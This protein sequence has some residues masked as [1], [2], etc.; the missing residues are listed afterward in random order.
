MRPGSG[1]GSR[2]PASA[3]AFR[4]LSHPQ[5]PGPPVAACG[6][7]SERRA[8]APGSQGPRAAPLPPPPNPDPAASPA[9]VARAF[10]PMPGRTVCPRAAGCEA[11]VPPG[12]RGR[13]WRGGPAGWDRRRG[14]GGGCRGRLKPWDFCEGRSWERPCSYSG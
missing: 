11:A 13:Q 5:T 12:E 2:G 6:D 8:E 1:P 4:P 3:S 9:E 10:V 7:G 14:V